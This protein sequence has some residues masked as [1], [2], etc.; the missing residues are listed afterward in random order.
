VATN[1]PLNSTL[2]STITSPVILW[3][4]FDDVK[5]VD[6]FHTG[7]NVGTPLPVTATLEAFTKD[8]VPAP[9]VEII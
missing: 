9:F 4:R 7:K 3:Y 1:L 8:N 6:V 5:P 2:V